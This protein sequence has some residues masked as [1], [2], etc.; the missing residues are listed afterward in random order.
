VP[1]SLVRLRFYL[2]K[3]RAVVTAGIQMRVPAHAS[4]VPLLRHAAVEFVSARCP[5][6]YDLPPRVALAVTEACSNVVRHAYPNR[7]GD[8]DLAMHLDGADV[9]ATVTDTG[10]GMADTPSGPP[11]AQLGL[12]L[13]D[14]AARTTITGDHGTVVK[15]RFLP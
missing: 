8:I 11:G 7:E 6:Q 15:M 3:A 12:L 13:L 10:V 2:R 1:G 5:H 4:Q 14:Q 9:V